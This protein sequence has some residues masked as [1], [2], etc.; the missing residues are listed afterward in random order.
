MGGCRSCSA[1]RAQMGAWEGGREITP[2]LPPGCCCVKRGY[3]RRAE[4]GK[5]LL[6]VCSHPPPDS[7]AGTQLNA[8][9]PGP[10][11]P[12]ARWPQGVPCVV[13]WA[14]PSSSSS[15]SRV[16]AV[17]PCFG[18]AHHQKAASA[19]A[20]VPLQGKARLP[21][22]CQP[23]LNV[24][25]NTAAA[26]FSSSGFQKRGPRRDSSQMSS[27]GFFRGNAHLSIYFSLKILCAAIKANSEK[28]PGLY[29]PLNQASARTYGCRG[30]SSGFR[31]KMD[32]FRVFSP[33]WLCRKAS[34]KAGRKALHFSDPC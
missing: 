11:C 10:L 34:T 32:Q 14:L 20:L 25:V 19:S 23:Q 12:P 8:E 24:P 28:T 21:C 5:G 6:Q 29:N 15:H 13:A 17:S 2:V 9:R 16:T 31:R 30:V 22:T 7:M 4:E 33:S 27:S 18:Q 3:V 1:R 26:R